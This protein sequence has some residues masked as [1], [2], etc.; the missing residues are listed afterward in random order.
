MS[1]PIPIRPNKICPK[2][3]L[4]KSIEEYCIRKTGPRKGQPVAHCK[5]CN[6]QTQKNAINSDHTIYRRIVWPS[7]LKRKYGINAEQYFVMLEMQNFSCAICKTSS[8]GSR[9][10]KRMGKT[11]Y[12]Y[13]D[14]CHSTGRVRGLLCLKCNT[15]IGL[16]NDSAEIA[17]KISIYLK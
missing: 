7:A 16:I 11:E 13:V 15:A 5:K 2:C 10:Y 9:H 3:K 12:F 14:H 6:V 4:E 1:N 17:E 8:P